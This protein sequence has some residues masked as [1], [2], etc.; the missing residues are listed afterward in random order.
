MAELGTDHDEGA[1]W[2]GLVDMFAFGMLLMML[3]WLGATAQGEGEGEGPE[4]TDAEI[5]RCVAKNRLKALRTE[6][7]SR[8]EDE[9]FVLGAVRPE[10]SREPDNPAFQLDSA[11]LRFE[12]GAHDLDAGGVRAI[13]NFV[14][15]LSAARSS[16]AE[17]FDPAYVV[18][19][20]SADPDPYRERPPHPPQD[21]V[22]LSAL[23]ASTVAKII[24]RKSKTVSEDLRVLGLG[25][26]GDPSKKAEY[27]KHRRVSL[28]VRMRLGRLEVTEAEREKCSS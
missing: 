27:G 4:R 1:I 21:N 22:E 8:I 17:R 15:A 6:L 3:L 19:R 9:A 2:P 25:S 28:E 18:L 11:E 24:Q 16:D 10:N 5:L 23:R 7:S 20:G 13:E 12:K 14:V 26:Q